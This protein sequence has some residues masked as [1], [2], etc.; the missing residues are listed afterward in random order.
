MTY[1]THGDEK[2]TQNLV[3]ESEGK[4]KLEDLDTDN[5]YY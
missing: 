2:C 3:K 5:I 4:N 1:C